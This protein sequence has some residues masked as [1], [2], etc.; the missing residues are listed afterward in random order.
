MMNGGFEERRSRGGY[1]T[2]AQS[3]PKKKC[4][5]QN[6]MQTMLL[7]LVLVLVLVVAPFKQGRVRLSKF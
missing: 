7:V 5:H 4:L 6:Q 3:Q 1:D 2:A